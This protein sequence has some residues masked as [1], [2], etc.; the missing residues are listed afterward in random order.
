MTEELDH[1]GSPIT[2][3]LYVAPSH[4]WQRQLLT[5]APFDLWRTMFDMSIRP[6]LKAQLLALPAEERQTL[7]DELYDSLDGPPNPEWER[8]WTMELS[9]RLSEIEHGRVE[10]V[11]AD[12]VH[13]A[14]RAEL[15]L[16]P[17]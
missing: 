6:E 3:K 17:R 8:A 4:L 16:P 11:D 1:S 15:Q 13:V 12:E 9:R 7:A 5:I 2:R 10:L 14:L